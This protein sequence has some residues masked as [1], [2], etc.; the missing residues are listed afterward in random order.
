MPDMYAR[1][2]PLCARASV[3]VFTVLAMFW[4][5]ELDLQVPVLRSGYTK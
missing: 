5:L 3:T 4:S 1:P 2:R